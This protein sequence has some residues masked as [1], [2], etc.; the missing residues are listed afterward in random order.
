MILSEEHKTVI[1]KTLFFFSYFCC[2]WEPH[3][4]KQLHCEGLLF[5]VVCDAQG[6]EQR[7]SIHAYQAVFLMCKLDFFFLHQVVKV[8]IEFS[9]KTASEIIEFNLI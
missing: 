7:I 8:I 2:R 9:Q 6:I 4:F 5:F 1:L 3:S